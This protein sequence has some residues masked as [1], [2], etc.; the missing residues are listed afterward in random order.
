MT[1]FF[2]RYLLLLL[3]FMT[4]AAI[5]VVELTATRVIAPYYGNTI[6][7]FSSVIGIILAALSLGYYGGGRLSDRYPERKFF[8]L[9]IA[10]GGLTILLLLA[11]AH[12]ILPRFAG[13]FSL[14]EGPLVFS[15]LLFFLPALILGALSPFAIKLQSMANPQLGLGQVSGSVFFWSTLGSIVGSLLTGFF[16]IPHFGVVQ[17][18]LSVGW[19]LTLLGLLG[20][21]QNKASFIILLTLSVSLGLGLSYFSWQKALRKQAGVLLRKDGLYSRIQVVEGMVPG[22]IPV[23]ALLLD[24]G[25]HSVIDQNSGKLVD[26]YTRFYG[27]YRLYQSEL[28][29][30]LFLGGGAYTMP[31]QLLKDKP[32]LR[33]DVAEVEPGLY[34]IGREFFHVPASKNLRS[35]NEDGRAFLKRHPQKYDYIFEDAFS[36]YGSMPMHMMTR[37]F[38]ELLAENLKD[39]GIFIINVIGTLDKDK[40]IL[41]YSILRTI[42]SVFPHFQLFAM[43]DAGSAKVQNFIVLARKGPPFPPL[44]K[45]ELQKVFDDPILQNL[46]QHQVIIPLQEVFKK[47]PIITDNYAPI[48]YWGEQLISS[49]DH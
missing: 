2:R 1:I 4:G 3:V 44:A 8:F 21:A 38:F 6:F 36:S 9:L 19:A 35:F 46:D 12:S 42:S 11:L 30:A 17:I 40:G 7:T 23:R 43:D 29:S 27:L 5:L 15:L 28:T 10:I 25:V 45:V 39:E 49:A 37:E 24:R 22:N 41:L 18:L 20:A 31:A 16:L 32:D 14:K 34:E 13:A 47:Y 33:I 26:P 48:E